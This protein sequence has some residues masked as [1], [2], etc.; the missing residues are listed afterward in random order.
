[1]TT[2]NLKQTLVI[3]LAMVVILTIGSSMVNGQDKADKQSTDSLRDVP[4]G[5]PPDNDGQGNTLE[6]TWQSVVTPRDCQTGMPAPFSF[7]TLETYMQ[8]GTMSEDNNFMDGPFRT[9]AHGIWQRTIGRQ[10]RVAFLLFH[11][12]PNGT[13]IGT[14]K[15]RIN[16]TL[17]RDFNS[18]SGD[19]INEV[20]DPNGNL[21]FMGCASETS[22]RFTF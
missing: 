10:Y 21:V 20:Y 5:T 1:M 11:F 14:V 6:G 2:R 12:T 7:K 15:V 16:R 13:F 18:S 19:S 17:S 8:G 9:S 3:A 22:T 4:P